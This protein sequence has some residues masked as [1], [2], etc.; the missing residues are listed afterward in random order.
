MLFNGS[1]S[2]LRFYT[3][4]SGCT[5]LPGLDAVILNETDG[6]IRIYSHTD[7]QGPSLIMMS[8]TGIRV[9]IVSSFSVSTP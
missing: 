8:N 1:G 6:F 7:C 2:Y 5:L 9:G 3:N 4:L